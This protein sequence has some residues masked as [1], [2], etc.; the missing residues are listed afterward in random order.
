V[1][2][3]RVHVDESLHVTAGLCVLGVAVIEDAAE[4][5][6]RADLRLLLPPGAQRLHW[7]QNSTLLHGQAVGAVNRHV[8]QAR[9]YLSYFDHPKRGDDARERC[10]VH[11]IGDLG[12]PP[13][14]QIVIDRRSPH[15]NTRDDLVLGSQ[16]QRLRLP[17]P[18]KWRHDGT[19]TEELLWLADTICGAVSDHLVHGNPGYVQ[20]LA[21]KLVIV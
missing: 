21:P 15:Q 11:M 14:E 3:H 10:L 13:Y 1:P 19:L 7:Q 18:P 4:G 6:A 2:V 9:A 17:H 5:Q 16:C 12:G 8:R 20:A